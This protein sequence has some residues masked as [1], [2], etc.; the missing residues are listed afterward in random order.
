MM[1]SR[2]MSRRV[3]SL[4]SL[5]RAALYP[6]A[7]ARSQENMTVTGASVPNSSVLPAK[8]P[9]TPNSTRTGPSRA[10]ARVA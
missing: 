3:A 6:A 10:L 5:R 4:R 9:I 2:R 8:Y 7:Q 1:A